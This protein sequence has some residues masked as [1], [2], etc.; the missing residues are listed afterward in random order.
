MPIRRPE[1][2]IHILRDHV[3]DMVKLGNLP[4]SLS[5][6]DSAISRVKPFIGEYLPTVR[7]IKR[8][9]NYLAV[10]IA[11]VKDDVLLDDFMLVSLIR[12][13]HPQEF[14]NLMAKQYVAYASS[15]TKYVYHALSTPPLSEGIIKNLFG[16]GSGNY[17]SIKRVD[18]FEFYFYD[19]DS[20][21]LSLVELGKV[22]KPN[23]SSEEFKLITHV[24]AQSKD[25]TR[26]F[27]AFILSLRDF[28]RTKEDAQ[29]YIRLFLLTRTFFKD[30]SL[31]IESISYLRTDNVNENMRDLGISSKDE[32]IHFFKDV[33]TESVDDILTIE[34]LHDALHAVAHINPNDA[35][36]LIFSY[37]ELIVWAQEKLDGIIK[38][39]DLGKAKRE[40]VFNAMKACV[41][42]FNPEGEGE[43]I[44]Q[45]AKE[46]VRTAMLNNPQT[47]LENI[48]CHK[49]IDDNVIQFYLKDED[50]YSILFKSPAEFN[51][52]LSII[53]NKENLIQD[54]C[55]DE[56]VQR[57]IV[58]DTWTPSFSVKGNVNDI[59]QSDYA[60]YN[61]LFEGEP[62]DA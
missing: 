31:Y 47:Y 48:L 4:Y 23:I 58:Q 10:S 49:I 27:I 17:R 35:P 2:Y 57:C 11:A 33:L 62:V 26:D 28:V 44:S 37:D 22:L 18:S 53:A 12:Y 42:E 54:N 46:Q 19:V 41:V 59:L 38:S 50:V 14:K 21:H 29:Y 34:F 13:K 24:W 51:L 36:S 5:T 6:I 39:V 8:Y 45:N 16:L 55:L 7:D 20:G 1:H 3:L 40:D 56:Y 52:F 30:H 32:Y 9:A 60:M 61:K 43:S 15:G 25:Y